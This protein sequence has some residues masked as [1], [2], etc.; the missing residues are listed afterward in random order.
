[1][2]LP[3]A[4][5][6]Q[7]KRGSN[8]WLVVRTA[9]QLVEL[10]TQVG[11][12]CASASTVPK[13]PKLPDLNSRAAGRSPSEAGEV[14]HL[15]VSLD[16]HVTHKIQEFLRRL[17]GGFHGPEVEAFVSIDTP[18]SRTLNL[19]EAWLVRHDTH[20]THDTHRKR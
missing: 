10:H 16:A 11:A 20:D 13:L 4:L 18:P 17:V 14:D 5:L 3:Q 9:A 2:L 15:P 1:V 19:I 8:A 7:V 6:L 12:R